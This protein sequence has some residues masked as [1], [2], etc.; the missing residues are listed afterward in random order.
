MNSM[1]EKETNKLLKKYTEGR[2][3]WND[4]Q[5][6]RKLFG[7]IHGRVNNDIK[8]N[9]EAQW[10]HLADTDSGQAESNYIL[11][12]KI[13]NK[14]RSKERS[15]ITSLWLYYRQAA[16]I[17][18]VPVLAFVLGYIV[19]SNSTKS[20]QTAWVEINAPQSSRIQFELPDGSSGWL[21]SGSRLK[22]HP[23]FSKQ[24]EVELAGEAYFDVTSSKEVFKVSTPGLE[25]NV[26]GT[27]FNVTA[28][29]N[30]ELTHVLLTEGEV[31]IEGTEKMFERNLV[32]NERLT[33]NP[34]EN[35]VI[36][37]K[38]EPHSFTAWKDGLLVLDNEPL[39]SAISRFERWYNVD[40]EIKDDVLKKYR[41][42]ATFE[43]EPLE[44]VLKLLS[45]STP[46]E[47]SID[48]RTENSAGIFNKKKVSI[49]LNK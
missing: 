8:N 32:P 41:F 47:Y 6:V 19:L 21:N 27:E 1:I 16:A 14:I 20:T 38:V 43:D 5:E 48:K 18:L 23:G 35:K 37:Q 28:Y 7:N 40:I 25:I 31:Q 46:M 22:Y 39:E 12:Q 4:F 34:A 15:K 11:Y 30:D 45:V 10:K 42:K 17:F 44:E 24:R 49:W 29:P 33:F 26:L 13:E 3:S 9:L 2:Y 36:V